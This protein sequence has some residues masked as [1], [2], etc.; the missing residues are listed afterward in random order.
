ML[1]AERQ[2]PRELGAAAR[3]L[4]HQVIFFRLVLIPLIHPRLVI[5]T[6][7]TPDWRT[8]SLAFAAFGMVEVGTLQKHRRQ[9]LMDHN[10]RP[11]STIQFST[12]FLSLKLYK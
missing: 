11:L 10:P 6:S 3:T 1:V 9:V 4:S 2:R 12:H 8:R 7:A 5:I